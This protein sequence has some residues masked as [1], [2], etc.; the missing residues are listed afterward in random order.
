MRPRMRS[1][2]RA[3][4]LLAAV[5]SAAWP[6]RAAADELV[7]S[8]SLQTGV[9]ATR[10]PGNDT[11]DYFVAATPQLAYFFG[12]ER[13]QMG[14]T[15][16]FTGSLN[17]VLPNGIANR[18]A[19]T[20]AYD[21]APATRLLFGME[22]LHASIGNYLLVRRSANTQV[23]GLPG[24]LNTTL[25]TVSATQGIS[26]EINQNV[27][28]TQSLG[29]TYVTSLD[30]GVRF[31]NYLATGVIGIDRSWEF[32][33]VGAELS[34]IWNRTVL[35][36]VANRNITVAFGPTWDH[37]FTRTLSGSANVAAQVAFSPDPDTEVRLAP[38]GRASLLYYSE[39]S[40]IEIS[41]SGGFEPNLLLGTLLQSHTAQLRGY[42][43]IS[44]EHR[45]LLSVSAAYLKAKT[46]DLRND[47]AQ[48]N[49]FDAILH[50][51]DVTWS[52]TDF[53]SLFVRYQFIGQ[54]AGTGGGATP[55]LV[56]HGAIVGVDL[57]GGGRRTKP[58]VQTKFPQRVDQKDT[59]PPD[60]RK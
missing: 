4:A 52:A 6:S 57:F 16:S 13:L 11:D 35:P 25:L 58:R 40:G 2:L 49:E 14:V 21:L 30:P 29:G 56:R 59:P 3:A 37:D 8:L 33:A 60:K 42:T 19:V 20:S 36:P 53:M 34:A 10:S 17:S 32:D 31:N 7:P 26:H 44:E 15:Y 43:P 1:L 23:G 47:G 27:R 22:A 9:T 12:T 55:P 38:A 28:L 45:V 48:D 41:Y 5:A 50:D 51:A 24:S 54:T 39:S 46:L 18:L